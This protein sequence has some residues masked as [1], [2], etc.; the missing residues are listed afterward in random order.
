MS[1]TIVLGRSVAL[2]EVFA[3]RLEPHQPEG[4]A[5]FPTCGK[6]EGIGTCAESSGL[7]GLGCLSI[8]VVD[9]LS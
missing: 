3:S 1:S 6:M 9:G 7:F 2:P 4:L 5:L 8:K